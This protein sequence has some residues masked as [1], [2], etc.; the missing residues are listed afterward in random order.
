MKEG[1]ALP[2]VVEMEEE[3][4]R[5]KMNVICVDLVGVE[6]VDV[7]TKFDYEDGYGGGEVLGRMCHLDG[8]EEVGGYIPSKVFW[9]NGSLKLVYYTNDSLPDAVK[10]F[11]GRTYIMVSDLV[12]GGR[13]KYDLGVRMFMDQIKRED[14]WVNVFIFDSGSFH[15]IIVGREHE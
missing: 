13:L 14:D 1:S 7:G 8:Y 9:S 10:P 11:K 5:N 15:D 2:S 6:W 12:I 4:S 3:F